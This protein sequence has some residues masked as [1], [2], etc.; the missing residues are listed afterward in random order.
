MSAATCVPIGLAVAHAW[1]T[2]AGTPRDTDYVI[3]AMVVAAIVQ[4]FGM[5]RP[6]L[7]WLVSVPI[8]AMIVFGVLMSRYVIPV[9]ASFFGH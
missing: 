9:T 1:R 2:T 5:L 4:A 6:S 3:A 7:A 8:A